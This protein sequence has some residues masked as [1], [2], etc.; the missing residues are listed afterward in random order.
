PSSLA[1]SSAP[2]GLP[3]TYSARLQTSTTL[4]TWLQFNPKTLEFSGVPPQGTYS[5]SVIL[6]IIVSSTTIPGYSQVTGIFRLKVVVHTL[7]LTHYGPD[8][9]TLGTS[10][11]D[12]I[13]TYLPDLYL[14][15]LERKIF[16]EFGMDLFRIDSSIRPM[17]GNDSTE[18][19]IIS[20]TVSMS[21]DEGATDNGVAVP[22]WFHLDPTTWVLTGTVPLD[23]PYRILLL[24]HVRDS[25]GTQATFRLQIFPNGNEPN[26]VQRT[27]KHL[28]D[29]VSKGVTLEHE[30]ITSG[31]S[32]KF[33]VAAFQFT[34]SIPDQWVKINKSWVLEID[35]ANYV[36]L[37]SDIGIWPLESMFAYEAIDLSSPELVHKNVTSSP[38]S[39]SG[40][41]SDEEELSLISPKVLSG[42]PSAS[43]SIS[44]DSNL[45]CQST[46]L[47]NDNGP[48]FPGW[49]DH[50]PLLYGPQPPPASLP[51]TGTIATLSGTV[52]CSLALR[53]RWTLRNAHA[54]WTATEFVLWASMDDPS[55]GLV[56]TLRPR[57]VGP[58]DNGGD[59]SSSHTSS[60]SGNSSSK[61]GVSGIV[62]GLVVAILLVLA[63]WYLVRRYY[64]NVRGD[65]AQLDGEKQYIDL[66][67]AAAGTAALTGSRLGDG[68]NTPMAASLRGSEGV[69]SRPISTYD[70]SGVGAGGVGMSAAAMLLAGVAGARGSYYGGGIA[71]GAAS[72]NIPHSHDGGGTPRPSRVGTRPEYEEA[73]KLDH[74]PLHPQL[75]RL[76]HELQAHQQSPQTPSTIMHVRVESPTA[77]S[78]SGLSSK[79][80]KLYSKINATEMDNNS[81]NI[82]MEACGS[83]DAGTPGQVDPEDSPR[84]RG[85]MPVLEQ[86]TPTNTGKSRKLLGWIT[87]SMRRERSRSLSGIEFKDPQVKR[88]ATSNV[89]DQYQLGDDPYRMRERQ[90]N[91]LALKRISMGFP[92]DTI[93][94]RASQQTGSVSDLATTAD[95]ASSVGHQSEQKSSAKMSHRQQGVSA[96][97]VTS[98]AAQSRQNT[99]LTV[100]RSMSVQGSNVGSLAAGA[101]STQASIIQDA[102]VG[103][104]AS[105]GLQHH[106][107][108]QPNP[109]HH[110][111]HP[112]HPHHHHANSR[113]YQQTP[114]RHSMHQQS[115]LPYISHQHPSSHMPSSHPDLPFLHHHYPGHPFHHHRHPHEDDF[116]VLGVAAAID[117]PEDSDKMASDAS[118]IF[119]R[120]ANR[121]PTA[122]QTR[123]ARRELRRLSTKSENLANELAS[124]SQQSQQQSRSLFMRR[125]STVDHLSPNYLTQ[126]LRPLS[127]FGSTGSSSGY[128][129]SASGG[130]TSCAESDYD[131]SRRQSAYSGTGGSMGNSQFQMAPGSSGPNGTRPFRTPRELDVDELVQQLQVKMG[132]VVERRSSYLSVQSGT[133]ENVSRRHSFRML[134]FGDEEDEHTHTTRGDLSRSDSGA[135][136]L[137]MDE[138]DGISKGTREPVPYRDARSLSVHTMPGSLQRRSLVDVLQANDTPL[139]P[140]SAFSASLPSWNPFK[141]DMEGTR[142][143]RAATS[144]DMAGHA[145]DEPR[146]VIAMERYLRRPQH[147][148]HHPNSK[149]LRSYYSDAE[150]SENRSK[151]IAFTKS[152]SPILGSSSMPRAPYSPDD[153]FQSVPERAKLV[154]VPSH[155]PMHG[156][157]EIMMVMTAT[158]TSSTT[159]PQAAEIGGIGSFD[160]GHVVHPLDCGPESGMTRS[161]EYV[162]RAHESSHGIIVLQHPTASTGYDQLDNNL[163]N[164][165]DGALPQQ[166][167]PK[168]TQLQPSYHVHHQH[169]Y[170]HRPRSAHLPLSY[171]MTSPMLQTHYDDHFHPHHPAPPHPNY[172]GRYF[173]PSPLAAIAHS[174][175]SN[176]VHRHSVALH[177][178]YST[179]SLF[180]SSDDREVIAED[181]E[182]DSEDIDRVDGEARHGELDRGVRSEEHVQG[183]GG[184]A[185]AHQEA[186]EMLEHNDPDRQA[187]D[188]EYEEDYDLESHMHEASGGM[189][190]ASTCADGVSLM[191][192]NRTRRAHSLRRRR[193][194]SSMRTTSTQR[195]LLHPLSSTP[196]LPSQIRRH[197]FGAGKSFGIYSKGL[198]GDLDDDDDDIWSVPCSATLESQRMA[199]I[200]VSAANI[201]GS[202]RPIEVQEIEPPSSLCGDVKSI[203]ELEPVEDKAQVEEGMVE[204]ARPNGEETHEGT[205]QVADKE[206]K[207]EEVNSPIPHPS[208]AGFYQKHDEISLQPHIPRRQVQKQEPPQLQQRP[209]SR[210]T[211][212]NSSTSTLLNSPLTPI[213][214]MAKDYPSSG[215]E[216][217]YQEKE[218]AVAVVDISAADVPASAS[219]TDVTTSPMKTANVMDVVPTEVSPTVST[220][221]TSHVNNTA[222]NKTHQ[223][224]QEEA[225]APETVQG[226]PP[227]SKVGKETDHDDE[228]STE[229]IDQGP[230]PI[231]TPMMAPATMILMPTVRPR[232][233]VP[234]PASIRTSIA[235]TV[236]SAFASGQSR[237][238]V[239][240]ATIGT[241]FH[242]TANLR[243]NGIL[244][245][246]GNGGASGSTNGGGSGTNANGNGLVG[247]GNGPGHGRSSSTRRS[248]RR[249][250]SNGS[251]FG[252]GFGFGSFGTGANAGGIG[253]PGAGGAV[254]GMRASI[255]LPTAASYG[256]LD[257][258]GEPGSISSGSSSG[259]RAL[260]SR[261]SLTGPPPSSSSSSSLASMAT[262]TISTTTGSSFGYYYGGQR[263]RRGRGGQVLSTPTSIYYTS[264]REAT[265][266]IAMAATG[267]VKAYL[268][269]DPHDHYLEQLRQ[270]E[271]Q[272]GKKGHQHPHR[273]SLE[274][275]ASDDG[276][277]DLSTRGLLNNASDPTSDP[278]NS[279]S[280]ESST[281]VP[282]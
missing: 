235:S 59:S 197:S 236:N 140:L 99:M 63:I 54:Q 94:P 215:I 126:S 151:N 256:R 172:N 271:Q 29:R 108:S 222:D 104:V 122:R 114:R 102:D 46:Q 247:S 200:S 173:V 71:S 186:Q 145:S 261:M 24:V 209:L 210:L 62:I 158:G 221:A 189:S 100:D 246:G 255:C 251:I 22:E 106:R 275:M 163:M 165:S 150:I 10:N 6:S 193:S 86:G 282:T 281:S 76:H 194:I 79:F 244:G 201:L 134:D 87:S 179:K 268:V 17:H 232:N 70:A 155:Q 148:D 170:L 129:A 202:Q 154:D 174:I 37:P 12:Y 175:P 239:V 191:L 88:G 164:S 262:T 16:Y 112:L 33:D 110:L 44:P 277:Q 166:H 32:S 34:S 28:V 161:R 141:A 132:S 223:E 61:G 257:E 20:I 187:L 68:R 177:Q 35:V 118:S 144:T 240:K 81:N 130:E 15:P 228:N 241:A 53:I 198:R 36:H 41:G 152:S 83:A 120:F 147:N 218:I 258:E 84:R 92:F 43:A 57:Q 199:T 139:S 90:P 227:T 80:Y 195:T 259:R 7:T 133:R 265:R 72:I 26:A 31:T 276:Y 229:Q 190:S 14:D 192:A 214:S 270:R 111:H 66:E 242:Y 93:R 8:F 51:S 269:S 103:G 73:W 77:T 238:Q 149:G 248:S 124:S 19:S 273:L 85:S 131:D 23:S 274:S 224:E 9:H 117:E 40:S 1:L 127:S 252:G 56:A 49:F 25:Y 55:P 119:H 95:Q 135:L 171:P 64:Q 4:P 107:L 13:S 30:G 183:G 105:T 98:H 2:A 180:S 272:P 243:Y 203:G 69:P 182:S 169:P 260:G 159:A 225:K 280:A 184:E 188:V 27:G 97:D 3:I 115:P 160:D 185:E 250:S 278:T 11:D 245:N 50:T 178:L 219:P 233:S 230:T 205:V 125:H 38:S 181:G 101:Q 113:Y 237:A 264:D 116:S 168:Q 253:G 52:P 48:L 279:Q 123:Q 266:R 58:D 234:R 207:V 162:R 263:G 65:R 121:R 18:P 45:A 137:M 211:I 5:S 60:T 138:A 153:M 208:S 39:G 82:P 42:I 67:S 128:L 231:P 47:F 226:E 156:H 109:H 167:Q 249:T 206:K 89:G 254:P 176:V 146:D 267:E 136:M 91:P 212:L 21:M 196:T 74:H 143:T 216:N 78:T 204:E 157:S 213:A 220:E 75:E 96:S 142:S 217:S